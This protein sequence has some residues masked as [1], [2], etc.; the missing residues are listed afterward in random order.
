MKFAEISNA[1][2]GQLLAGDAAAQHKGGYAIDSRLV[3]EGDIFIALGGKQ[4][5][6]SRDEQL[7]V[8]RNNDLQTARDGHD[9]VADA[10]ARGAAGAIV[11]RGDVARKGALILVDNTY[12]ALCALAAYKRR[13]SDALIF[14]VTGSVGK[15]SVRNLLEHAL[16]PF[17]KVHATHGNFNNHLGLPLMML[18]ED[19]ADYC[20]YELGMS[21]A[22][23]IEALSQLLHPHIAIITNI[24]TSHIEF[25]GSRENIARAKAEIFRGL[26]AAPAIGKAFAVIPRGD[27][28]YELLRDA[29]LQYP[30]VEVTAFDVAPQHNISCALEAVSCAGLDGDA[31]LQHMMHLPPVEGRGSKHDVALQHGGHALLIDDSY[32]A[33]PE[34]MRLAISSLAEYRDRRVILVLGDM[35]ELGDY[36][37]KYHAEL[38]DF[39]SE[40]DYVNIVFT[41]GN[42]MKHT[43]DKLP[44]NIK[45]E[46]FEGAD[47]AAQHIIDAL[48]HGDVIMCKGSH[49]SGVWK[50]A[51]KLKEGACEAGSDI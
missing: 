14:A 21:A 2:G 13:M 46:W 17:G 4:A 25:L 34:S 32:N 47:V 51:A 15:T 31:A 40:S 36:S 37:E 30:G 44:E 12:R 24:G 42:Y 50:I 29:A 8:R 48:Q 41:I 39:I 28:Y 38:A 1:C 18:E 16:A 19:D 27:D 20:V 43:Y 6:V 49:G 45:G 23:E 35:L 10:F 3:R 33:A 5:D 9:F 7:I 26:E 11:T 22:G